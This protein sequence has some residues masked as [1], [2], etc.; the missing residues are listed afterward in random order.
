MS[1]TYFVVGSINMDLV[2][3]TRN[4][5]KPEAPFLPVPAGKEAIRLAL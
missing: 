5:P 3:Q 1:Y 2:V 4:I